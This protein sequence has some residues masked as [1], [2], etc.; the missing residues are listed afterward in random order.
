M[1]SVVLLGLLLA[2]QNAKRV[3]FDMPCASVGTICSELARQTGDR[4][5]AMLTVRDR[6]LTVV[7]KSVLATD[8][9]AQMAEILGGEWVDANGEQVLRLTQQTLADELKQDRAEHIAHRD[10]LLDSLRFLAWCAKNPPVDLR[11]KKLTL[12]DY[13]GSPLRRLKFE[14]VKGLITLNQ[15]PVIAAAIEGNLDNQ[16]N[17]LLSGKKLAF[18]TDQAENMIP[19]PSDIAASWLGAS[20]AAK[21]FTLSYDKSTR[22]LT[23]ICFSP[24]SATSFVPLPEVATLALPE[25]KDA[26]LSDQDREWAKANIGDQDGK[27]A[28]SEEAMPKSEYRSQAYGLAEHA[29]YLSRSY[30]VPV[31]ADAYRVAVARADLASTKTLGQYVRSMC[32]VSQTRPLWPVLGGQMRSGWLQLRHAARWRLQASEVSEEM[33]NPIEATAARGEPTL[34]DY[35]A[36]AARLNPNQ[37]AFFENRPAV[38]VRFP[39]RPL[40]LH[41][42]FLRLWSSFNQTQRAEAATGVS[43]SRMTAPQRRQLFDA[44]VSCLGTYIMSRETFVAI[45]TGA[46]DPETLFFQCVQKPNPGPTYDLERL[47]VGG[48][49][50]ETATTEQMSGGNLVQFRVGRS[51]KDSILTG[52]VIPKRH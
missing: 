7:A 32:Q 18:S 16:V 10:A 26:P 31:I 47:R 4:Y 41:I 5:S 43:A 48:D 25:L 39:A 19:L 22:H 15:M 44:L 30:G 27:A 40:T 20:S 45:W 14:Q 11:A 46:V 29:R 36:L 9:R 38:L 3:T 28:I 13:H 6:K 23:V 49:V 1:T 35:A 42:P 21:R 51:V 2:N 52:F 17:A 12:K 8:L 33:L 24:E 37:F 34:G 50:H